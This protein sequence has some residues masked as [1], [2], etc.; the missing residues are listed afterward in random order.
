MFKEEQYKKELLELR[1]QQ[2]AR[3]AAGSSKRNELIDEQLK[4]LRDPEARAA[5]LAQKKGAAALST[6]RA[7]LLGIAADNAEAAR[8]TQEAPIAAEPIP[9]P[10][11]DTPVAPGPQSALPRGDDSFDM[12]GGYPES[13]SYDDGAEPGD[14]PS[15]TYEFPTAD[16]SEDM[17]MDD[18]QFASR[19][20]MI[21]RRALGYQEGGY[22]DE[23]EE[24]PEE[25]EPDADPDDALAEG[26]Y[27][28]DEGEGDSGYRSRTQRCRAS[29]PV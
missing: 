1:K 2:A 9:A 20:G 4:R 24:D 13:N 5:D 12:A 29:L 18:T 26:T 21:K 14:D 8:K 6:S 16:A 23:E 22:V 3:S 25:L 7:R 27:A 15:Y 11:V 19:G 10:S 28:Y 17:P